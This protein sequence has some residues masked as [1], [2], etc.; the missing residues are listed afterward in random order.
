MMLRCHVGQRIGKFFVGNAYLSLLPQWKTVNLWPLVSNNR[1]SPKWV[2][3]IWLFSHHR[4]SI[5][6]KLA[7]W[8]LQLDT[9]CDICRN[10]PDTHSHLFIDCIFVKQVRR[11]VMRGFPY[12]N[13]CKHVTLEVNQV[14]NITKKKSLMARTYVVTWI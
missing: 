11:E 13:Q 5:M 10:G 4:L 1:A 2:F 14:S 12:D 3:I 9:V 8:G 7:K 6:D